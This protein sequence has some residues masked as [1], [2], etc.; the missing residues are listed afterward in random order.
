MNVHAAVKGASVIMVVTTPN[1]HAAVARDIA[2]DLEDG[3]IIMIADFRIGVTS[4]WQQ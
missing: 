1:A 4:E 2:S 3:Q